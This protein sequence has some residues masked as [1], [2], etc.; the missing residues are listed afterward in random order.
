MARRL[1]HAPLPLE[2]RGAAPGVSAQPAGGAVDRIQRAGVGLAGLPLSRR[3][4]T[5]R[6]RLERML[7]S[8]ALLH[9]VMLVLLAILYARQSRLPPPQDEPPVQMVFGQSGMVGDQTSPDFGGGTPPAIQRP[10]PAPP[11]PVPVPQPEPPPQQE[12]TVNPELPPAPPPV[13]IPD[14]EPLPPVPPPPVEAQRPSQRTAPMRIPLNTA[15][16]APS[17]TSRSSPFSNPMDLS[18]SQSTPGPAR[19]R[20]GRPGGS[21]APVDLS[22]GP[23]VKNGHLNTPFATVG[24][25]GVSDD[26]GAEIDSWIRRHLFYPPEAAQRGEDG[27]SH[28]HVVIDREGHVKSV[29][30]VDSAGSFALDDSTEGMFRNAKL[31]PV[32]PDMQGDHFDIDLTVDYILMR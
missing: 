4:R 2:P 28:V 20:S 26:Y 13:P 31:P 14:L 32:P 21:H 12:M 17:H 9:A 16:Q 27:N 3:I 10:P 22:L 18:F 29:R 8:S 15:R 19:A 1:A 11:T 23:L 30:L 6:S 7:G 5:Q 24:I 25:K